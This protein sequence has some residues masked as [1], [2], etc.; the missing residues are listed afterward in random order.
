MEY[1]SCTVLGDS[2]ICRAVAKR[3]ADVHQIKSA[4]GSTVQWPN[5]ACNCQT[6]DDSLYYC[7]KCNSLYCNV[8]WTSKHLNSNSGHE[9]TKASDA[10]IVHTTLR[11]RLDNYSLLK[12]AIDQLDAEQ[13]G[14]QSVP[15]SMW[16]GV[17]K[18]GDKG[19]DCFLSEGSAYEN[20]M[21][22]TFGSFS[23]AVYPGFV[24]FV[25]ETGVSQASRREKRPG[26]LR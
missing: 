4:L 22:D 11:V 7:M 12:A 5:G 13:A 15:S 20:L 9:K 24:S 19:N 14:H 21:L 23:S 1:L 2:P 17:T 25:G 10:I 18:S 3:Y 16:F 26:H 8:C 6:G